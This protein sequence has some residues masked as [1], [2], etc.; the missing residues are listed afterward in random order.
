MKAGEYTAPLEE[1][2]NTVRATR[3]IPSRELQKMFSSEYIQGYTAALLDVSSVLDY[4]QDDLKMHRRKQNL[5]TLKAIVT[6]M[7]HNRVILREDPNAFVRCND[8]AE[9]GFEVYIERKGV[10]PPSTEV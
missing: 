4:I 9:G 3:A 2:L 8:H 7:V 10:Y 1:A 6:C 5:N